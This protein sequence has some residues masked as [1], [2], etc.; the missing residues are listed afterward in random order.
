[1]QSFDLDILTQVSAGIPLFL[2]FS[3]RSR[4]NNKNQ[5][6]DKRKCV[7]ACAHTGSG[8][9]CGWVLLLLLHLSRI[10]DGSLPGRIDLP[11]HVSLCFVL[12][13]HTFFFSLS[14]LYCISLI[15][16]SFL[17]PCGSPPHFL[18]PL[19]SLLLS[20]IWWVDRPAVRGCGFWNNFISLGFSG[21]F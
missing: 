5:R 20:L 19:L 7:Y 1:M 13:C 21:K 14:H 2:L 4:C 17:P 3:Y 11:L 12:L 9:W 16:R 10:V 18:L 6:Q 15:F 8:V